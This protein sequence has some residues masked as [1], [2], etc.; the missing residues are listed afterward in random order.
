MPASAQ[1][2][3]AALATRAEL[4]VAARALFAD[5]GYFATGTGDIVARAKVT[6]GAL[7]HHFPRKLDLFRAAFEAVCTD[8]QDDETRDLA[9]ADDPWNGLRRT[10]ALYMARAAGDAEVRQI[11]LIDGP[12]VLGWTQWRE[13]D[14]RYGLGIIEA[15]ARR[16]IEDGSIPDMPVEVLAHIILAI[17]NEGSLLIAAAPDRDG[18]R[19][20][21][22]R[23]V[24]RL[25]EGLRIENRCGR[26]P[27]SD[28]IARADASTNS[29][30]SE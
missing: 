7:Q 1:Q 25:L 16:A 29:D 4:V 14:R 28:R 15:A 20:E 10:I 22:D 3:E 2:I 26:G 24:D 8:M 17:I 27:S 18:R 23:T 19:A 9:S 11:V 6:R 13:L 30:R 21:V 5:H 12:A